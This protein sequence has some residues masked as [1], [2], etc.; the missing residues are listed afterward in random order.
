MI[1]HSEMRLMFYKKKK[2]EKKVHNEMI[3]K[4]M[5]NEG[6]GVRREKY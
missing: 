1:I 3:I 4:K 6:R 2:T 5:S